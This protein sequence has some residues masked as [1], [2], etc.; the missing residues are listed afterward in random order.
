MSPNKTFYEQ[1]ICCVR[2]LLST[3]WVAP[4]KTVSLFPRDPQCS[5]GEDTKLTLSCGTSHHLFWYTSQLKNRKNRVGKNRLLDADWHTNLPRFQ[6][7]RSDH[8]RIESSSFCFPRELVNLVR[9]L[10]IGKRILVGRYIHFLAVL[11]KARSWNDQ[12]WTDLLHFWLGVVLGV[13][14]P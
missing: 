1:N 4:K 11:L 8:V 13:A 9:S 6:G 14:A 2:T 12:V 5:G 10:P 7:A 3:K